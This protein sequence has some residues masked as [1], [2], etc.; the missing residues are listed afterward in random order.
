MFKTVESLN[1][2]VVFL[3]VVGVILKFAVSVG[4]HLSYKYFD[5]AF[6]ERNRILF[7]VCYKWTELYPKIEIL[8]ELMQKSLFLHAKGYI[9]FSS[10]TI[11]EILKIGMFL[12]N[13]RCILKQP[14]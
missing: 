11:S 2:R 12:K 8:L 1:S 5:I 14:F 3:S 4:W 6:L 10:C 7:T 9:I 13:L